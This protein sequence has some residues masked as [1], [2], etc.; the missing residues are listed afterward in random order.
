MLPLRFSMRFDI[1]QEG[2]EGVETRRAGIASDFV[3]DCEVCV[4]Y[5]STLAGASVVLGVLL[6]STIPPSS[7]V[8]HTIR[9]RL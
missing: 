7:P 5:D 1:V 3:S 2:D 9:Y 8:L 6:V 4:L